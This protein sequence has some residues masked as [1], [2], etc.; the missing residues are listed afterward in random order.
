VLRS[1]FIFKC[2]GMNSYVNSLDS[3][4]DVC[5]VASSVQIS[6]LWKRGFGHVPSVI[7][8]FTWVIGVVHYI[9]SHSSSYKTTQ[10]NLITICLR[11]SQR[12]VEYVTPRPHILVLSSPFNGFWTVSWLLYVSGA[13]KWSLHRNPGSD[14]VTADQYTQIIVN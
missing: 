14:S 7:R 10:Q 2:V 4:W 11:A 6:L 8:D 5:F 9:G 12:T 13:R 1:H 3:R